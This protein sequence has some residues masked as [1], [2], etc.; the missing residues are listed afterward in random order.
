VVTTSTEEPTF[1][2][3]ASGLQ[4]LF[5]QPQRSCWR[6]GPT[7]TSSCLDTNSGG[8]FAAV[9]VL[10]L[11]FKPCSW[12]AVSREFLCLILKVK[13][14]AKRAHECGTEKRHDGSKQKNRTHKGDGCCGMTLSHP[15]KNRHYNSLRLKNKTA[16]HTISSIHHITTSSVPFT[17]FLAPKPQTKRGRFLGSRFQ[18]KTGIYI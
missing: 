1:L 7:P 15:V 18:Q 13:R 2:Q 11:L 8:T 4:S 10:R 17:S 12:V 3:N 16:P 5:S 6:S 9:F 14:E